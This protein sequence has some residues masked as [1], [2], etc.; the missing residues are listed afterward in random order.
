MKDQ[1]EIDPDWCQIVI[2]K[3][4]LFEHNRYMVY[5]QVVCFQFIC[6]DLVNWNERV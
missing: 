2:N 3:S 4:I 6:T 1:Q 5:L